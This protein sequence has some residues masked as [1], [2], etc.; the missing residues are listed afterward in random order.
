MTNKPIETCFKF[1]WNDTEDAKVMY[2]FRKSTDIA[3][4]AEE[5]DRTLWEI[6]WRIG[7]ALVKRGPDILTKK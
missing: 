2:A 1:P 5:R 4:I 6:Q 7:R 3:I